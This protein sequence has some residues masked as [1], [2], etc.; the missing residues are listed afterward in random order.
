MTRTSLTLLLVVAAGCRTELSETAPPARGTVA[1]PV[2][3][4]AEVHR[5]CGDCH[6]T[7]PASSFVKADWPEEVALGYRL[8]FASGR[9]DLDPP[10]QQR[11]V[12]FYQKRAPEELTFSQPARAAEQRVTFTAATLPQADPQ[13]APG[14]AHFAVLDQPDGPPRI[15][16]ADMSLGG[17]YETQLPAPTPGTA[18]TGGTVRKVGDV[19]HPCHVAGCD[20]NG[21]GLRELVVADLGSFRP[22]DHQKGRVVWIPDPDDASRPPVT[23]DADLGRVAD[24][25]PGD[26]DSDGDEDLLVAEFGW[27]ETGRILLLENQ[28]MRDGLPAMS[29]HV[30]DKRHG[31]IHAIPVDFDQDGRLDFITL[32]AQEHESVELFLATGE[33][34]FAF[35]REVLHA[36]GDPAFGSSGIELADLDADG[37]LD[38][39]FTNGDAFDSDLPKPY[40]GIHWLENEGKFPFTSHL[41]APMPGVHRAVPGDLDGD[42]DLDLL[43]TAHLPGNPKELHPEVTFESIAWLEQVSRGTFVLHSLEANHCVHPACAVGDFDRDGDVD[44][45][46]GEFPMG[47]P[48]S[49]WLRVF[50]QDGHQ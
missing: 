22:S 43:A 44:L 8:Y 40:H 18:G 37:D 31:A 34:S 26:F 35:R 38:V 15:F 48:S 20:L 11:V 32:L 14:V 21:D 7:P 36:A 41:L 39:V 5:F 45:V 33:G 13:Q 47:N 27:R 50:W 4:A 16:F 17:V 9:T 3:S 29:R 2:V 24:V 6:A 28:G 23:L 10:P 49:Q 1:R 25:R 42:G 19:P 46:V 12:D 30:L